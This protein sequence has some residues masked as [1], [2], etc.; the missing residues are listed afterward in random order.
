MSN[1]DD[2][3][4]VPLCNTVPVVAPVTWLALLMAA[5][6]SA[7]GGVE[8]A[9]GAEFIGTPLLLVLA[10]L[11]PA[12]PDWLLARFR[13]PVSL[14][15]GLFFTNIFFCRSISSLSDV[16]SSCLLNRQTYTHTTQLQFELV[17]QLNMRSYTPRSF[18][19]SLPLLL[20]THQHT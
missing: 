13:P 18:A 12:V 2:G 3:A 1:A 8:T 15:D 6:G 10:V 11:V 20:H 16:I 9:A 7:I 5:L 14:F 4:T 17:Q 19:L